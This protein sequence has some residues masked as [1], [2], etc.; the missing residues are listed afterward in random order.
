MAQEAVTV[1]I[2]YCFITKYF[3][4]ISFSGVVIL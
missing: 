2:T 3:Q 4:N 1:Q